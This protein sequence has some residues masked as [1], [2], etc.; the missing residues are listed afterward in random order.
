MEAVN[1]GTT[2][3]DEFKAKTTQE[4]TDKAKNED[5][6]L[7]HPK[8][9]KPSSYQQKNAWMAKDVKTTYSM[10][11][12][13][14]GAVKRPIRFSDIMEEQETEVFLELERKEKNK[15]HRSSDNINTIAMETAEERDLRLA[16]EASLQES[17][18]ISSSSLQNLGIKNEENI[19]DLDEE[20][21][22]VLAM[23]LD[24]ARRNGLDSSK[25]EHSKMEDLQNDIDK[26]DNLNGCSCHDNQMTL[27]E[28]EAKQITAAIKEADDAEHALSIE[29]AMKLEK[30]EQEQYSRYNTTNLNYVH[31]PTNHQIQQQSKSNVK[32][33]TRA[34]YLRQKEAAA[35]SYSS[36][37]RDRTLLSSSFDDDDADADQLYED[38][39]WEE[40]DQDVGFRLNTCGNANNPSK[41]SWSRS[42]KNNATIIG[43]KGEIRS[44]HDVELKSKSNAQRLLSHQKLILKHSDSNDPKAHTTCEPSIGDKA[45]NDFRKKMK[46]TKK[47]VATHGHGRAEN[48]GDEKTR[49]GALD[50][51][52]R[53]EIQKAINNGIIDRM[54]GVVKEGK[55]ALVYHADASGHE[56]V[57][58]GVAIKVF[59]RIQEFR[60]RGAYVDGDPRYHKVKFG[61]EDKRN[62]VEIW[63]EKVRY[64][65][66]SN[67][68][69]CSIYVFP[70][71]MCQ[72]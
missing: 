14:D 56:N 49:G 71:L 25:S 46:Q 54:N 5:M 65:L 55:E 41:S 58:N 40:D 6:N 51:N 9:S 70:L 28:E 12:N 48:M 33:V 57:R 52:V 22:L 64:Q 29:L 69:F 59:K 45:Y 10:S 62:Q 31:T 61:K 13:P 37:M 17:E 27:S 35:S 18:N 1:E 39:D 50:G 11:Q 30:E 63:T 44:K 15:D 34:E 38:D 24:E 60:Q 3:D 7:N 21:R 43:P 53:M 8:D 19:D 4:C 32:V 36:S 66:F 67:L 72:K 16:I 20:M 26:N 23:S 68:F 42:L 47:G 2:I